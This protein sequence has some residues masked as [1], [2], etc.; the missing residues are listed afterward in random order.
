MKPSSK[1]LNAIIILLVLLAI[2]PVIGIAWK[3]TGDS[4]DVWPHLIQFVLPSSALT[5]L[6][7][8]V[9]VGMLVLLF[10]STTAWLVSRYDFAF[11]KTYSWAL[12]L[13][14]AMPTYLSA[15]AYVEFLDF[16]GP[17]QTFIRSLGGFTSAR[18]YWFPDIRST[19]GA[20]FLISLVLYPYVYLP[21]RLSFKMQNNALLDVGRILGAGPIKLFL[22]V[23]LPAAR[24]ALVVGLL[25]ALMETLNDIGAVEYLGVRTLTFSI[26][27]TWLNRSSLAGASQIALI[28]LAIIVLFLH[29][30]K[31]M[32][33]RQNYSDTRG[34][35]INNEP[36]KLHGL[37][38]GLASL[39][40]FLPILLG[41]IIPVLQMLEFAF[42][43]YA[44]ALNPDFYAAA[45]N[46]VLVA[47]CTALVCTF[48]AFILVYSVRRTS[49]KK[50]ASLQRAASFGY[51]VPGTILALG[52]LAIIA[53]F[54]N[55]LDGLLQNWFNIKM[56]LLFSGSIFILIYA[57]S[58]R[59]LTI[60]IGS[61][62]SG[63]SKI[64][65]N[66]SY[67]SRTLG[68]SEWQSLKEIDLALL[69]PAFGMA[70]LLVCVDSM[71]ELS[72][73]LLLRPFNFNTLSTYVYELASRA[74]FEEAA[75]ASL[76]IVI[77]GL[78]PVYLLTKVSI[79]KR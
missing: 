11:K 7:L 33:A 51:A 78:V 15:Y 47:I 56:G 54:D 66:L 40:C 29:I 48:C 50:L 74:L 69:R 57:G 32:R 12:V 71:K 39:W 77:I 68:R 37:K 31:R 61:I 36:I 41:F 25:L 3:A 53:Q 76:L 34:K 17:I 72:A 45:Y 19:T 63:Y 64:S 35:I 52:L 4:K 28:L 26:Y 23:A 24:P 46:S 18:D 1:W 73:T 2:L 8:L 75:I 30:E 70:I 5:T 58:V 13:P 10:G 79:S 27:D 6:A 67:A 20:V 22:K 21:T 42:A 65:S 62:E 49:S 55:F 44:D 59:F 38:S 14:L 16:T 43:P 60:A 9:G